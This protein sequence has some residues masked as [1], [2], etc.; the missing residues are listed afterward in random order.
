MSS[1]SAPTRQQRWN[2]RH[3]ARDPIDGSDPDPTLVETCA[4]LPPGR[5]LDLGTGAGRNAIWLA[6]RGWR[7][8]AVDFS[9]AGLERARASATAVGVAGVDWQLHDLVEWQPPD[10]A[11]ELVILVFIQLPPHERRRVHA[12]AAAA[13]APGG[14]LLVIGHDRTNPAEE[15]GGPR[16]QDVLFTAGEI[17][18]ELPA[19]FRV[20]RAEAVPRGSGDGPQPID[21]V[22]VA[23]R[24]APDGLRGRASG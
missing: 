20:E 8:T 3:A 13:V 14:T 21:A 10:A 23:V 12:A 17:A 15:V 11:F 7:V 18:S 16:D 5:A 6:Q 2:E 22:L 1:D 4:G 24:I 9:T 19:G